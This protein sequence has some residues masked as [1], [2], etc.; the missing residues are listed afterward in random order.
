MRPSDLT[1]DEVRFELE[2]LI[3]KYPERTGSA[4]MPGYESPSC[5]YYADVDGIPISTAYFEEGEEPVLVEPVCIVGQWIEDF[6]AEFKEH[7]AIRDMLMKNTT[8]SVM[9]P[10][11]SACPFST[12]VWKILAKA[13]DVQDGEAA[14]WNEIQL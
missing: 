14:C 8:L 12:E 11:S 5:V 3:E 2:L 7:S 9:S 10:E 4:M 13:Q 6:H 1:A